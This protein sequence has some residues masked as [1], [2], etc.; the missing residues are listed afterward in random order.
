MR[1]S[2]LVFVVVTW[3][4]LP[5]GC[6]T[7]LQL[8]QGGNG[9][10]SEITPCE[11]PRPEVCTMNYDPVCSAASGGVSKTY[12]NACTACSDRTITGYRIG[13]CAADGS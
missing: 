5:T 1:R 6:A 9:P 3:L 11:E 2:T 7:S 13:A 8:V 12:S 4:T 10:D